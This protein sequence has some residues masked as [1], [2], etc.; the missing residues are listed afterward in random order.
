MLTDPE[1]SS[2]MTMNAAARLLLLCVAALL[3]TALPAAAQFTP[4]TVSDAPTG[5][6]FHI[7]ASAGLWTG[8]TQMSISSE[9]LGIPG[10]NIDFKKDLGLTDHT[11]KPLSLTLRPA[12]KH[13][14]RYQYISLTYEQE[15]TLTRDIIF[16]GIR[17]K[18]GVPVNSQLDWK[19]HRFTYE[20]DVVARN[21]GFVGFLLDAKYT[22]VLAALQS[23]IDDEFIHA[24]APVPAI[25]GIGRYY[26]APNIAITGELSG[27]RLTDIKV[28][29]KTQTVSGHYG[30]LD[31]YGTLNFTNSFGVQGGYRDLN[32]GYRLVKSTVPTDTGSFI[33]KGIYI[34][35]VARF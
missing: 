4:R 16:Q 25:G 9:S 15:A 29:G 7:E 6:R 21:W 12:R 14:F 10:S 8:S 2:A 31:I 33:V 23:P 35:A 11:F 24:K 5:E 1:T 19:A 34:N 30:E 17:Y 3:T 18:V 26:I 27:F 28:P 20:Y 13:K 32:L 22:N